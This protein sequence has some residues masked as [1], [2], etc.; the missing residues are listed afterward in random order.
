[1][2]LTG[3]NGSA[4]IE[5][6]SYN[7][8][9]EL[10]NMDMLDSCS[11]GWTIETGNGYGRYD[12]SESCLRRTELTAEQAVYHLDYLDDFLAT[13]HFCDDVS[14]IAFYISSDGENYDLLNVN[15]TKPV[16]T[17]KDWNRVQFYPANGIPSDTHY[18]MIEFSGGENCWNKHLSRIQFSGQM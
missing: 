13:I 16:A 18:L 9:D 14:G 8:V 2:T 1:M 4:P 7:I 5:V 15:H 3:T 12:D 17:T 11:A 10:N 6:K